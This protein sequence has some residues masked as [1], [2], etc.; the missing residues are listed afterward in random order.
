MDQIVD[1][2]LNKNKIIHRLIPWLILGVVVLGA[3]FALRS[4]AW[5]YQK[6]V[7]QVISVKKIAQNHTTDT[8]DNHATVTDQQVLVKILNRRHQS[9][10][11][12]SNTYDTSQVLNQQLKV[13]MQIF[14]DHQSHQAWGFKSVKRDATWL[15]FLAFIFGALMILMR[16]AGRLTILSVLLN[17]IIFS[18]TIWFDVNFGSG[19]IV[20]LFL[21]FAI[22]VAILTLGLVMG[23]RNRQTWV[24]FATVMTATLAALGLAMLVFWIT[25]KHGLHLELLEFITQLPGPM[26]FA[27]T[28]VGVLGAVM[29][30]S[31]DMIATL[32]TLKKETPNVTSTTLI[33]AGRN[34]GQE[35]FGA[36]IN[37]LLLIF[38]AAQIPMAILYLRNGN[39]IGYTY[40]MN[41]ALGMTQTLISAIGI[42]LTVPAGI[43]WVLIDNWFARRV[44]ENK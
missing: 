19:A 7:G 5:F 28:L 20:I 39:N 41:M 32:F 25:G 10:I 1:L 43:L 13:G 27:M 23:F 8:Y 29:D 22:F 38:I 4:D 16:R 6:P 36:L 9:Q 15:P 37:V 34:V 35:I 21:G 3:Y 2:K 26:F 24:I 42:V 11:T 31:T 17:T 40:D 18:L 44:R 30:E 14:L 12:I 33:Q